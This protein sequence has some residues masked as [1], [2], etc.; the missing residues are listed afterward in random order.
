LR[1]SL[2]A[3]KDNDI[4]ALQILYYQLRPITERVGGAGALAGDN[5]AT[6]D[7]PDK[8]STPMSWSNEGALKH[9]LT[10]KYN[11]VGDGEPAEVKT[12]LTRP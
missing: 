8:W 4:F 2:R 11:C 3:S 12:T 9:E 6:Q 10:N 7:A 1:K 5:R